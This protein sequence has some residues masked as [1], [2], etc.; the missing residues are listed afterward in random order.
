MA[1]WQLINHNIKN[2]LNVTTAYFFD[3][4][5]IKETNKHEQVYVIEFIF[6]LKC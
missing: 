1:V 2:I 6:V 3:S 5:R 4:W